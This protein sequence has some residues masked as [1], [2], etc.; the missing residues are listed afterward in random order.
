MVSLAQPSSQLC[1]GGV[2]PASVRPAYSVVHRFLGVWCV[3]EIPFPCDCDYPI[4]NKDR[5]V[6]STQDSQPTFNPGSVTN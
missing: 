1:K 4:G 3:A 2:F 6:W 5:G